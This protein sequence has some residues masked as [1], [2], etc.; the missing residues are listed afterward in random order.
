M[1]KTA[2]AITL[3]TLERERERERESYNLVI[4]IKNINKDK[5]KAYK[6]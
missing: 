5:T 1:Q 2:Q 3:V 4:G 6:K